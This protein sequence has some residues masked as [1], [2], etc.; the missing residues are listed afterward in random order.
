MPLGMPLRRMPVFLGMAGRDLPDDT[1]YLVAFG[2]RGEAIVSGRRL[3]PWNRSVRHLSLY[4]L[5]HTA[6]ETEYRRIAERKMPPGGGGDCWMAVTDRN[7]YTQNYINDL[8]YQLD[9]TDLSIITT[10]HHKGRLLGCV[11][12]EALVYGVK[13]SVDD[14]IIHLYDGTRVVTLQPPESRRWKS[15]TLSACRAGQHII[16]VEYI[17]RSLDVFTATGNIQH[18]VHD[19]DEW[20]NFWIS[21]YKR[22]L[23]PSN[24]CICSNSNC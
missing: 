16:V 1:S 11:H 19:S 9:A 8:T 22:L 20:H 5:Q 13:R 23:H 17:S 18:F 7:I 10:L 24:V 2:P 15:N 12:P 14:W 3:S 6:G 21:K 4:R